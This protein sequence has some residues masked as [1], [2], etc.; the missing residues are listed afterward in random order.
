MGRLSPQ[1]PGTTSTLDMLNL[2]TR[3]ALTDIRDQNNRS[4]QLQTAFGG[5]KYSLK[6]LHQGDTLVG[7]NS[8]GISISIADGKGS[9]QRVNIPRD[10][11]H[12]LSQQQGTSAP[13][14]S[15]FPNNGDFGWYIN[16]TTPPG[17]PIY[18]INVGGTL[19][20][21]SNF[22]ITPI[23]GY[24]AFTGV[25]NRGASLDTE[26]FVDVTL[27]RRVAAI[28]ADLIAQGILST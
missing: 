4:P 11:T 16:T 9:I 10:I 18:A 1:F 19:F 8:R 23:G 26:S 13:T 7:L 6:G 14:L 15:N 21:L 2:E 5:Q 24:T 22:S 12:Y 27:A 20:Q 25:L 28:Q 17:N 3:R